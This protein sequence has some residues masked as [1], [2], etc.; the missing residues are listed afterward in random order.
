MFEVVM[1]QG[2]V[3]LR[4]RRRDPKFQKH[5]IVSVDQEVGKEYKVYQVRNYVF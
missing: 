4:K 3:L 1:M 2:F 5:E